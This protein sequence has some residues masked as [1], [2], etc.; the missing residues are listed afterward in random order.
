MLSNASYQRKE[1]LVHIVFVLGGSLQELENLVLIL[2]IQR[3]ICFHL[4]V[5][6][7]VTFIS[8]QYH[9]EFVLIFNSENLLLE[10]VNFIKTGFGCNGIHQQKP[11]TCS[12]ILFT[13]S[14]VFLLSGSVQNVQ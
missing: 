5:F 14:R 4:S 8:N 7:Q 3:F 9:R 11:F 12:H 10:S 6:H 1:S 13:H 2:K